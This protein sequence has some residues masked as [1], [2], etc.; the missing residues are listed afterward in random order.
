MGTKAARRK[1]DVARWVRQR[2]PEILRGHPVDE[3]YLFGSRAR[4]EEDELSD[5]DLIVVAQSARPFVERFRDFPEI[6]DAPA[7]V[8]LLVYTPE[9][10]RVQRR[11]SRF[12]RHALRSARQ[13]V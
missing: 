9:E 3:A 5:I 8:D 12:L 1:E 13:I 6:L 10:F 4:G 7:G 11:R 2:L